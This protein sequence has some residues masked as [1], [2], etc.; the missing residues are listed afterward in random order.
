MKSTQL[1]FILV[2]LVGCG[3]TARTSVPS[4]PIVTVA[5]VPADSTPEDQSDDSQTSVDRQAEQATFWD[6]AQRLFEKAKDSGT[7]T[8]SSTADWVAELYD[9]AAT[10]TQGAAQSSTKWITEKY[11]EAVA[12]GE[13]TATTA[14]DWVFDDLGKIGTWQYKVVEIPA[15]N[16]R[17]EETELNRL[18]AQRWEGYAVQTQANQVVLYLKRSHRSYLRFLPAKD[19]FRLVPLLQGDGDTAE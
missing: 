3:P 11:H 14:K 12:S 17:L 13:T 6:Q 7:T 4:G 18:G 16:S 2:V 9:R 8:A 1:L 5:R 15:P 10:S 19:L